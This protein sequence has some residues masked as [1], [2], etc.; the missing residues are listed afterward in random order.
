MPLNLREL[1]LD[2]D[3]T[4]Q[5]AVQMTKGDR[6]LLDRLVELRRERF[7]QAQMAE[8]M[9]VSQ[10]AVAK[11]ERGPRD[12]RL[13]TIRRYAVALGVLVEHRVPG[14]DCGA[15]GE[16]RDRRDDELTRFVEIMGERKPRRPA[17]SMDHL[18]AAQGLP[19][20]T[21]IGTVTIKTP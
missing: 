18:T 5:L 19:F 9:G 17:S 16:S 20:E 10:S 21:S 1:G 12:P 8:R 14:V 15:D 7:T 3:P 11:F 13:S 2:H 4:L 6:R